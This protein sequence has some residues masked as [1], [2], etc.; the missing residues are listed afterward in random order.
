MSFAKSFYKITKKSQMP[1]RRQNWG[2]S[3]AAMN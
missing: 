1:R 2:A 3:G